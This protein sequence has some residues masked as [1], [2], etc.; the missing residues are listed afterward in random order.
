MLIK[1]SD[2][3]EEVNSKDGFRSYGLVKNEYILIKGSLNGPKKRLLRFNFAT[4]SR[5]KS[6]K[7]APNIEHISLDSQQRK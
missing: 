1:I 3:P 2:K 4:R 5:G 7:E 6:P